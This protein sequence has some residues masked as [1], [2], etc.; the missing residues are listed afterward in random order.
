MTISHPVKR[1]ALYMALAVS[2]LMLNGCATNKSDISI[3]PDDHIQ[4]SSLPAWTT[5]PPQRSGMA[6]GIGS[7][8]IHGNPTQ[9]VQRAGELAR[10][11]LVSQLKVTVTGQNTNDTTEFRLNGESSRVQQTLSQVVKS[12]IPKAELDEVAIVK[13]YVDDKYAYALAELD[14]LAAAARIKQQISDVEVKLNT[15]AA[16]PLADGSRLEQLQQRLPALTEFAKRAQL[17]DQ[18]ALISPE[19]R[20]PALNAG[21]AAYRDAILNALKEL[22][23]HLVLLDDGAKIM[24]GGLIEALTAQGLRLNDSA[25]ADLT[26]EV[27]AQLDTREQEGNQYVFANSRVILRDDQ[28]KVIST[29]SKQAKGVSGIKQLALQKASEKVADLLADELAQSLVTRLR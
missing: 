5:Q 1:H 17:A 2:G 22:Q 12:Q 23:V 13:T 21:L 18:Y 4:A 27:S 6:Y 24:R 10:A 29:F 19:R 14:R 26:F 7:M 3:V 16:T 11:D 8:D 15:M 28:G 25:D 9:A 20:R